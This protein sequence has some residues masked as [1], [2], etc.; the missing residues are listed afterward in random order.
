MPDDTRYMKVAL[1]EAEKALRE[2]N[3]P[4]G[5]VI[6]LDGK[7][8]AKAHNRVYSKKDKLAHAEL[9]A[10]RQAQRTLLKNRNQ[11]VLYTTYEPCPMCF[12]AAVLSK[13]KRVVCGIDLDKSGAMHLRKNLPIL[14]KQKKFRVEFAR[15]VLADECREVF[16]RSKKAKKLIAEGLRRA[17]PRNL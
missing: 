1:E 12:G 4:I 2:K 6:V 11:A 15:G 3:W 7:I 14:F 17:K 13:V 16:M 8:I 10:L 9:L 5:C